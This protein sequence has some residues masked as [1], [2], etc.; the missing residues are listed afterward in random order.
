MVLGV[1]VVIVV[2]AAAL[3]SLGGRSGDGGSQPESAAPAVVRAPIAVAAGGASTSSAASA[4]AGIPAPAALPAQ[5]GPAQPGG[6]A[7]PPGVQPRI[8]W[9]GST[10]LEVAPGA[11]DATIQKIS[12]VAAGLGGYLSASQVDGTPKSTDGVPETATITLRVPA[13]SFGRLRLAVGGDGTVTSSSTTSQDVTAD[14]VD[15][16]ARLD[17]LTTSR[18]TYLALMGRA[19]TVSDVLAVQAQLDSVQ[20]QIEQIQGQMKVLA[21]QSDLATLTVTLSERGATAAGAGNGFLRAL[22]AAWHGFVRGLEDIVSA[23]GVI[24][25]ILLVLVVLVVPYQLG[26]RLR[27]RRAARAASVV[28]DGGEAE[29]PAPEDAVGGTSDTGEDGRDEA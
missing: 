17:A 6:E 18:A 14:Y 3:G 24:A 15:L 8:V 7:R 23:L 5:S 16:Q 2:L 9:T 19:A 12:A 13:A 11:V 21:D 28:A 27:A 4:A 26:R 10:S 1:L 25:V 29:A 20:S 22:R